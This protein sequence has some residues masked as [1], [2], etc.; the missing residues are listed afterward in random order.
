MTI[1]PSSVNGGLTFDVKPKSVSVTNNLA[2]EIHE[3]VVCDQQGLFWSASKMLVGATVEMSQADAKV[4]A[5]LIDIRIIPDATEA[6]LL[7]ANRNNANL[8]QSGIL[9]SKLSQWQRKFPRR[10]FHCHRGI[11]QR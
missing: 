5:D 2:I 3:L 9:E 11:A 7:N 10:T 1:H 4:A 6:P 8:V